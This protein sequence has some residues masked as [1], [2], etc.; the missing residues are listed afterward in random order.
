MSL[1]TRFSRLSQA[2]ITPLT[3]LPKVRL[4]PINKL[5]KRTSFW[6]GENKHGFTF[7]QGAPPIEY[8]YLF[9][10]S[11]LGRYVVVFYFVIQAMVIEHVY[12]GHP[13]EDWHAQW[14]T[15][16][17]KRSK[18]YPWR[19]LGDKNGDCDLFDIYCWKNVDP[20]TLRH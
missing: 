3:K 10:Q 1:L 9:T 17:T 12:Y 6:T 13:P 5:S 11:W 8:A 4:T 14:P 20:K 2:S 19:S 18:P 15:Y 16:W 7:N